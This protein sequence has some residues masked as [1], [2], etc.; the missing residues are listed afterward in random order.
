MWCRATDHKR[1]AAGAGEHGTTSGQPIQHGSCQ[2]LLLAGSS[3]WTL[4]RVAQRLHPALSRALPQP[5]E[6]PLPCAW[7]CFAC[8]ATG[9]RSAQGG[10]GG[11]K[12]WGPSKVTI[13]PSTMR[14]GAS[15]STV[16]ASHGYRRVT[17]V[18][19]GSTEPYAIWCC[20]PTNAGL[21]PTI[22]GFGR[23]EEAL[24]SGG[25]C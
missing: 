9:D 15:R 19:G 7:S 23:L 13:W 4:G 6:E 24:A 12:C 20:V 8:V 3:S 18:S 25:G 5:P 14:W 10:R 1:G 11:R 22:P 21:S 17:V 16:S 2:H